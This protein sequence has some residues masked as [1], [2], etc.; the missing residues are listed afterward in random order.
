MC[1]GRGWYHV[2][3]RGRFIEYAADDLCGM[4]TCDEC[5]GSGIEH[6]CD[7]CHDQREQDEDDL[8]SR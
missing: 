6:E 8:V 2:H 4:E 1:E 7:Y 5:G 3:M